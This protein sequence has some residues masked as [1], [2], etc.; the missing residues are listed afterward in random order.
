MPIGGG[1]NIT[2]P[3]TDLI[4]I[5][6]KQMREKVALFCQNGQA[7]SKNRLLMLNLSWWLVCTRSAKYR[8]DRLFGSCRGKRMFS[9][10]VLE[11]QKAMCEK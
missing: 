3:I 2:Q 5:L 6:V 9:S 4:A 10:L 1:K 11:H 7:P 8:I